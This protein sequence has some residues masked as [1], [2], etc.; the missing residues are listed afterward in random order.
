MD[1]VIGFWMSKLGHHPRSRDHLLGKCHR[2]NVNNFVTFCVIIKT[3]HTRVRP[4]GRLYG[5]T[6]FKVAHKVTKV[7]IS[8]L[9][10][11]KD[12]IPEFMMLQIC[13]WYLYNFLDNLKNG[14]GVS[15]KNSAAINH[16]NK[17]LTISIGKKS[18]PKQ[19]KARNYH[20]G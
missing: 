9:W 4:N 17:S 18:G 19:K 20:F 16:F 3:C 15:L 7:N 10:H 5:I 6:I 1:G 2:L 13:C 12:K 8:S 11:L 14:N